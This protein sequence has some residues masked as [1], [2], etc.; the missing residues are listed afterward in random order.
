MKNLLNNISEF[1]PMLECTYYLLQIVL[2][3]L[4]LLLTSTNIH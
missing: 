4:E 2:T 1:K 3:I